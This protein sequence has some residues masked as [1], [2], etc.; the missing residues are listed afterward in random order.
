MSLVAEKNIIGYLL[1][2]YTRVATI[3]QK[4]SREM[5]IKPIY[6]DIYEECVNGFADGTEVNAVKLQ[7]ELIGKYDENIVVRELKDCV[8]SLD[9]SSSLTTCAEIVANDYRVRK[10]GEKI[11]GKLPNASNV[12]D[13]IRQMISEL[14]GLLDDD[15]G[16]TKSVAEVVKQNK[17]NYFKPGVEKKR[18][19]F[20]LREL[21]KMVG[22]VEGGD[23]IVLA[24]RPAV[25]KSAIA[26]QI[27]E[28]NAKKGKKVGYFNL[29]MQENQ[30]YERMIAKAS[31]IDMARIR[32]ATRF[33]QDEEQKFADGNDKLSKWDNVF[34][35]TGS[36][37]LSDL[38]IAVKN[39][40]YD[41][42]VIDYLQLLKPNKGRGSNR[43]AEVGDISRGV[44]SIASDS[45]V[46][47]IALSQLNRASEGKE[48][49]EPNM[50]ELRESGDIEQDASVI[51]MLWNS[52]KED[53]TKKKIKVDKARQGKLGK[54][55]LIFNGATM[56]FTEVAKGY[57]QKE[58][59]KDEFLQMD[60]DSPFT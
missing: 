16:K 59:Q 22:G 25:G 9:L 17:D 43:Y 39:G 2:D 1:L 30:V 46:P 14:E 48:D 4:I 50:S 8:V 7:S 3:E 58:L 32:N 60:G 37:T 11:K 49:K 54:Q 12:N 23:V 6:G 27:I 26:L 18:I 40:G 53:K 5:F 47:I 34:V 41:L 29:E 13:S 56:T 38:R 35:R 55:D 33:L 36:M 51:L 10:F 45:D 24:A 44:K 31:G 42:V 28:Y 15:D 21:D 20:G 57:N 52:D 19:Y